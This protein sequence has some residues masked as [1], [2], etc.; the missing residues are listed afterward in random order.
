M[1][2]AEPNTPK[3]PVRTSTTVTNRGDSVASI[4]AVKFVVETPA[5][6]VTFA[7]SPWVVGTGFSLLFTLE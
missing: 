3:T 1:A 6:S 5:G 4:S 2:S 7:G